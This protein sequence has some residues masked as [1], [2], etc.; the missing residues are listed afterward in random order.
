MHEVPPDMSFM[1]DESD[2]EDEVAEMHRRRIHLSDAREF[3]DDDEDNDEDD[4][5]DDD[6]DD[7]N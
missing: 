4:D 3:Y 7:Y 6:A 2:D 5:D 1:D